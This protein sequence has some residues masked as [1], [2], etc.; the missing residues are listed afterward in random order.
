MQALLALLKAS[1]K[2]ILQLDSATEAKLACEREALRACAR[3]LVH[4]DR[5]KLYSKGRR[6]SSDRA[7]G[8][9]ELRLR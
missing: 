6:V 2:R 8:T 4:A 5:A 7:R 1:P 9:L 3:L